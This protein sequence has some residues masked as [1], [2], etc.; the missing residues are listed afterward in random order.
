MIQRVIIGIDGGG[1]KTHMAVADLNGK[2]IGDYISGSTNHQS[3]LEVRENFSKLLK[4]LTG[5]IIQQAV[6]FLSGWDF[7]H[8]KEILT[9]YFQEA[10]EENFLYP[11]KLLMDNDIFA[12]L[13]S[14]LGDKKQGAC[15][16]AGS[17]ILSASINNLELHRSYGFGYNSGEWGGGGDLGAH[18]LFYVMAA[19]QGRRPP[20]PILTLLFLEYFK[21]PSVDELA[22]HVNGANFDYIHHSKLA[23]FIFKAAQESCET[24]IK[25]LKKAA[26]EHALAAAAMLKKCLSP[27]APL[28][29]GGGLFQHNGILPGF[30]ERLKEYFNRQHL[31]IR[32]V[33]SDPVWGSLLMAAEIVGLDQQEIMS[34]IHIERRTL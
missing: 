5:M 10:C 32:H 29:L 7:P 30:E 23:P 27:S 28:I 3:T 8:D 24:S 9:R 15:L 17:G 6:L 13:K 14:G 21:V 18:G 31:E 1:S 20:C 12:V 34:N 19:H 2:V 22:D 4:H 16:I 33:I 11:E 26:K 25:I